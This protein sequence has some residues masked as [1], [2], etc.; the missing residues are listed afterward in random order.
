MV[1]LAT[2]TTSVE[3][4]REFKVGDDLGWQQPDPNNTAMYSQWAERNRFQI[5]DSLSFEYKNDSVLLVNKWGYYHC[6]TSNPITNL[7]D[8]NSSFKL[9][10]SGPFYFISGALDHCKNGQRL[11]V[12]V[13]SPH[14]ISHSPPS[15]SVPPES[16]SVSPPA[17]APS[18]GVS[19][20]VILSSVLMAL[21]ATFV[22]LLWSAP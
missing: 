21:F 3:A 7:N 22:V 20:S 9:D 4:T 11:L 1:V 5:G 2:K 8:G 10:R 16:F 18:S 12:E 6:N 19:V 15:I 17:P 14:L 13:M